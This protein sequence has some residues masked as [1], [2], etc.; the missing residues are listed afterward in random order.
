MD[1]LIKSLLHM[2]HGTV[3]IM[4]MHNNYVYTYT[5]IFQGLKFLNFLLNKNFH[6]LIFV[7]IHLDAAIIMLTIILS[8]VWI[9]M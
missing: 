9:T 8:H 3:T 4:V 1:M 5:G 6:D 7:I 2:L